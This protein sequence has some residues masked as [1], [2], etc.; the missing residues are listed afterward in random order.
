MNNIS[1]GKQGE[2]L[3]REYLEKLGYKI[4]ETNKHFSR[5]CEADII[6]LD[7]NTLVFCEVKTRTSTICGSPFEAI[8]PQK[9]KNMK[10]AIFMYLKDNPQY[11]KY[12]LDAISIVLEPKLD[13]K[14][15]KNI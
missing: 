11:K 3:A 13:I 12:R 5:Y 1:V 10:T 8:T 2:Q 9:Y 6:A 7:K 4:L 15:L 14:H